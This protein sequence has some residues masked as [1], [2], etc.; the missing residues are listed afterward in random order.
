MPPVPRSAAGSA[1]RATVPRSQLLVSHTD[2]H[3]VQRL[4]G[5]GLGTSGQA[6]LKRS[7]IIRR[8]RRAPGFFLRAAQALLCP[9]LGDLL[10]EMSVGSKEPTK[11][12]KASMI[13]S[14]NFASSTAKTQ[15]LGHS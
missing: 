14:M 7:H 15:P 8:A 11:P 6:S 9:E 12:S 3:H 2:P 13:S 4:D 1:Q 10:V 5:V